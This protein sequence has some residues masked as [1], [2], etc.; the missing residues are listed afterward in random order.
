MIKTFTL[1]IGIIFSSLFFV[2]AIHAQAIDDIIGNY[3][4]KLTITLGETPTEMDKSIIISSSKENGKIKFELPD[5][6]FPL[7]GQNVNLGTISIDTVGVT[8]DNAGKGTISEKTLALNLEA[9]AALG[10]EVSVTLNGTFEK[11]AA[12]LTIDV[13]LGSEK[14]PVKF[15]GKKIVYNE[16][17]NMIIGSYIGE[18]NVNGQTA[19][20]KAEVII[21]GGTQP[22]TIN[23]KLPKFSY[24][25]TN[26]SGVIA[27]N[28]V[29]VTEENGKISIKEKTED[30]TIIN[31]LISIKLNGSFENDAANLKIDVNQDG[32][33]IPATFTGTKGGAVSNIKIETAKTSIYTDYSTL[34]IDSDRRLTAH[35]YNPLG[36]LVSNKVLSEGLNRFN[37]Q[38]GLYIVVLSDGTSK[39]VIVK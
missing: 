25:G 26:L 19:D 29:E 35:I 37:L 15:S 20:S 5:F 4:G 16:S 28:E 1:K 38:R 18:V 36:Q 3:A 34:Y 27:V 31:T 12:D 33:I 6:V 7:M 23:F 32:Q 39:K 2:S 13:G 24:G 8:F 14:I 10:L 9:L 11:D 21:T 22:N 17:V 30:I